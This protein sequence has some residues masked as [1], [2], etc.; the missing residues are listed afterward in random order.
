MRKISQLNAGWATE[1]S[2]KGWDMTISQALG[3]AAGGLDKFGVLAEGGCGE[4][5]QTR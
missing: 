2:A 1:D 4:T 5:F 3:A